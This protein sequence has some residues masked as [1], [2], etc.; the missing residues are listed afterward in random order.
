[1]KRQ[2]LTSILLLFIVATAFPQQNVRIKGKL[3][4]TANA[5]SGFTIQGKITDS[6]DGKKVMLTYSIG[7]RQQVRDSVIINNGVFQFTGKIVEPVLARIAIQSAVSD[8]VQRI[9]TIDNQS[10]WQEFYLENTKTKINGPTLAS[11]D[12]KGG[13]EQEYYLVYR[14]I[15]QPYLD[16]MK[17][18]QEKL[19]RFYRE[20]KPDS[21]QV[22]SEA[23]REIRGRIN[24]VE[25]NYILKYNDAYIALN[26][27]NE[28]SAVVANE[29]IIGP[30]FNGLS[31]RLKSSPT[32]QAIGERLALARK[33]GI[34]SIAPNFAQND[35]NDKSISLAS[36]KGKYV[37]VD[38]WASWCGPCRQENPNLVA[39][40]KEFKDKNFE[41]L[42][43]SLD[44]DKNAW[45]KAIANDG[46]PWIHVSDLKGWGNEAAALYNVRAVPQNFLIGPDG[47]IIAKSLRGE[48]LS[49]ILLQT[50]VK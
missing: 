41:I 25:E 22:M 34:G 30:L 33:L 42:A 21:V 16:E 31:E 26:L 44:N 23:L 37:L 11:A 5:Q 10:D 28:R 29:L 46:L 36:L 1:M 20:N 24:K 4:E 7:E 47:R 39:A 15:L 49:K 6:T 9:M 35:P 43:V 8:P 17:P 12:I 40:Y 13:K 2:F 19:I 45:L 14:A 3:T 27:L 50:L 38:F 18:F 32:G 48:E